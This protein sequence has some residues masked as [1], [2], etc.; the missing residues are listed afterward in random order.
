MLVEKNDISKIT[1]LDDQDNDFCVVFHLGNDKRSGK[2]ILPCFFSAGFSL[3]DLEYEKAKAKQIRLAQEY[4][5]KHPEGSYVELSSSI[6]YN[7]NV[8]H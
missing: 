5:D 6:L 2:I 7:M 1:M 4:I 3:D 8:Y